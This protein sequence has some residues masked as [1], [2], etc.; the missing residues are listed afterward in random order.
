M[1]HARTRIVRPGMPSEMADVVG[2]LSSPRAS[3]VHGVSFLFRPL[4]SAYCLDSSTFWQQTEATLFAENLD[5]RQTHAGLSSITGHTHSNVRRSRCNYVCYYAWQWAPLCHSRSVAR[6]ES[7]AF[8]VRC[9]SGQ[10]ETAR[11]SQRCLSYRCLATPQ[12]AYNGT[13]PSAKAHRS[14]PP[15]GNAAHVSQ[16]R[17][18]TPYCVAVMSGNGVF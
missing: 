10:T 2:F 17:R 16:R 8:L 7:N 1:A 12:E 15:G 18:Q 14:Y 13:I 9:T 11:Q 4:R 6:V 3:F 5:R